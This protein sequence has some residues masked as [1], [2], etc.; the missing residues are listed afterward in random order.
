[1][2]CV[3]ADGDRGLYAVGIPAVLRQD[4]KPLFVVVGG[5]AVRHEYHDRSKRKAR[6]LHELVS[7]ELR[8][9]LSESAAEV[10]DVL[11]V[12]GLPLELV[13]GYRL[14][15]HP[16][17]AAG[18]LQDC[19]LNIRVRAAYALDFGDKLLHNGIYSAD[20]AAAHAAG[21]VD[22]EKQHHRLLGDLFCVV[23]RINRCI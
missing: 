3:L 1:M 11:S 20:L 18:E 8:G 5:I 9:K 14:V 23:K 22:K 16:L 15:V 7:G 2:V 6:G 12:E 17:T 19:Q 13:D 4:I 21:A 10:G